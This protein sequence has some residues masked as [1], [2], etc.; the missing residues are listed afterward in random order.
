MPEGSGRFATEYSLVLPDC[1]RVRLRLLRRFEE[2][3]I[4]E[5]FEHL[6]SHTRYLRFL[7][8]LRELPESLLRR[9]VDVDCCR[10]L[11]LV[12]EH[13]GRNGIETVALGSFSAVDN[14]SVEVGLVVRDDW[15]GRRLGSE[16]AVRL[17]DTAEACGFHRFIAHVAAG[18]TAIRRIN[19]GQITVARASFGVS[20]VEFVRTVRPSVES[21]IAGSTE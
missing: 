8:P 20:E 6:S 15:Q 17:L 12:A 18:N 16:L 5:L 14:E 13:E 19:L 2:P 10:Q 4:R 21:A 11:A 7:S 3:P 1:A 9:L